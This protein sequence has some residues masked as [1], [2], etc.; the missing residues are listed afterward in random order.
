MTKDKLTSRSEMRRLAVQNPD[1]LV[2]EIE[3]LRARVAELEQSDR[4]A[5]DMRREIIGY[6]ADSARLQEALSVA[7]NRLEGLALA[8]HVHGTNIDAAWFI[9]EYR[10]TPPKPA[11]P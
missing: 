9:A 10:I 2:Q 5:A 7:A 4:E 6:R 3:R 8:L 1:A 11:R